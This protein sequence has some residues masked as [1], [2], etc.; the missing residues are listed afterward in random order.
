MAPVSHLKSLQALDMALRE[1]S[2]R[3]AANR[4]GITP[5]A[6]GQRIRALEEHL[7]TVLL[8]RGPAGLE[9]CAELADALPDLHSAFTALERASDTLDLRRASEIH[10]VADPDW[11]ELWLAPRLPAFLAAHPNVRFNI[12]GLGDVPMRIGTPDLRIACTDGPE[13]PLFTD[14]VLPVTGPDNTRRMEHLPPDHR[15]EGMPLLHVRAQREGAVPG[16]VEWCRAFG[17]RNRGAD[18]G[19]VYPNQRLAI[20]AVR[21]NVGFLVCGLSLC[22]QD[23]VAGRIVPAFP[24]RMHLPARHPYRLALRAGRDRR[25]QTDRFLHWLR[26]EARITAAR[27]DAVA[28]GAPLQAA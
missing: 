28:Q 22:L 23:L 16:W 8:K 15:L 1:G 25:P 7:D 10:I 24:P 20:E 14:I 5:A 17:Q 2:L 3:E 12:N 27:I 6:I 21:L 4:L 11:A 9:P 26:A 18:R 13:E 19:V